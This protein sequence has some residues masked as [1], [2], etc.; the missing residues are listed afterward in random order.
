MLILVRVVSIYLGILAGGLIHV[1]ICGGLS[2]ARALFDLY[3]W[4]GDGQWVFQ[5]GCIICF[6]PSLSWDLDLDLDSAFHVY[7]DSFPELFGY[8]HGFHIS[9]VHTKYRRFDFRCCE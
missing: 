9:C 6:T 1:G 8:N 3:V 5:G 7:V 2:L 4:D